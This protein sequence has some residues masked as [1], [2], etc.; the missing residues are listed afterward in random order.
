MKRIIQ[1]N[2]LQDFVFIVDNTF[3][4]SNDEVYDLS[5][6]ENVSQN[7]KRVFELIKQQTLKPII[8]FDSSNG[9]VYTGEVSNDNNIYLY[10]ANQD[11]LVIVTIN[12]YDG[13]KLKTFSTAE[14]VLTE[15]NVKRLFGDKSIVGTGNIDLYM[16][17]LKVDDGHTTWFFQ[18]ISSNNLVVDSLQDLNTLIKPTNNSNLFIPCVD[19]ETNASGS[20]IHSTNVWKVIH[21]GVTSNIINVHDVVKTI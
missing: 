12:L 7:M 2:D 13:N 4:L 18:F 8:W 9:E 14:A 3:D 16:H 19:D 21:N 5:D 6:Y 15:D 20:L 1:A 10:R 17:Y 11:T